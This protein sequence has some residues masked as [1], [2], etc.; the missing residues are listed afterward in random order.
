MSQ[1]RGRMGRPLEPTPDDAEFA[2]PSLRLPPETLAALEDMAKRARRGLPA[3][4]AVALEA[5]LESHPSL[6]PP[7]EVDAR[8]DWTRTHLPGA[9]VREIERRGGLGNREAHIVAAL[10]WW[11]ER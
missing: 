5:Y 4:I 10:T 3:E 6:P 2:R 1:R 7:P 11:T 9:I 8:H